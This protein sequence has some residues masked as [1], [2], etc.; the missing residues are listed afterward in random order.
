MVGGGRRRRSGGCL[1]G[2]GG[3]AASNEGLEPRLPHDLEVPDEKPAPFDEGDGVADSAVFGW[4]SWMSLNDTMS[5]RRNGQL[6][7]MLAFVDGLCGVPL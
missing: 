5:I 1:G 6:A 3:V 2:V 4:I 7:S